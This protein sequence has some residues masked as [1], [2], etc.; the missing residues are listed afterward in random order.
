[1]DPRERGVSAARDAGPAARRSRRLSPPAAGEPSQ[2]LWP[3]QLSKKQLAVPRRNAGAGA[4]ASTSA[5][6][7]PPQ[8]QRRLAS[9][10]PALPAPAPAAKRSLSDDGPRGAGA[11]PDSASGSDSEH[12]GFIKVDR[13]KAPA[14]EPSL[15]AFK[16]TIPSSGTPA[17][18]AAAPARG[19]SLIPRART[20]LSK[21][22]ASLGSSLLRPPLGHGGGHPQCGRSPVPPA[23]ACA[24]SDAPPSIASPAAAAAASDSDDSSCSDDEISDVLDET[25]IQLIEAM[26]DTRIAGT[27]H[28]EPSKRPLASDAPAT[29]AASTMSLPRRP[30]RWMGLGDGAPAART[31]FAESLKERFSA[32]KTV[33]A[34]AG[35]QTPAQ[36]APG[37]PTR[38]KDADSDVSTAKEEP[39][40]GPAAT[41]VAAATTAA[42]PVEPEALASS[43]AAEDSQAASSG[44]PGPAPSTPAD[45]VEFVAPG[46]A[47]Q[48]ATSLL[49]RVLD[50][51]GP[52]IQQKMVEFL[53][54]DGVIA[55]LIGF[56]THCQGSIYS[57]GPSSPTASAAPPP[58]PPS[59][60]PDSGPSASPF[61]ETE[62]RR[63]HRARLMRQRCRSAGL[64]E[65]DLRRGFNAVNMLTSRDQH[66]RRVL[67]AKLSVIVPCLMAVFHEDSLGSFH[68]ACL[69]LEHCFTQSPLKTTRLLLYQQNPPSRWWSHSE[70]VARGHAPICDI[71][72]YLSEPCVQRLFLKAEFGV[73]TG[74]LMT[75]LN[76]SSNDAMVVPEELSRIG[77]GPVASA[78]GAAADDDGGASKAQSQQRSK[79]MQLVRNRFQQLNRGGFL[80]QAIEL[81]E[82]PDAYISENVAEFLAFMVSDCSTFYGFNILFKP[83]YDSELPVR[84][85]AQLILSS[86]SQRLT[87]QAVAATRL[88]HTLLTKTSCQ[89]GLRTREAQGIRDPELHP[90][91]S[92]VLVHVGH[93]ARTALES[94]LPGLF[95][96]ATGQQEAANLTSSHAAF[97]RRASAESLQL[98]EFDEADPEIDIDLTEADSSGAEGEAEDSS[99]EPAV[100]PLELGERCLPLPDEGLPGSGQSSGSDS[101]SDGDDGCKEADLRSSAAALLQST[102]PDSLGS[103][104]AS[105]S[106]SPSST[107]SAS[108]VAAAS[109]TPERPLDVSTG[110]RL[111]TEDLD[112]LVSLP[113]PDFSRLALLRI[114]IEVLR[115]CDDPDEVV[116]WIDLRVWR[117]LGTWFLNHPHNNMLHMSMYQL[118]SIITLEAVRLRKAR[119]ERPSFRATQRR[120]GPSK[121]PGPSSRGCL[122]KPRS[123]SVGASTRRS[124]ALAAETA[125][126]YL[127][128]DAQI[129]CE[130]EPRAQAAAKHRA[131]RRRAI[132]ERIRREEASSCDGVLTY[133]V[134][135]HRWIDKL[136]WRATSPNFDGARGYIAL[137][138][139]TLR[140]AIQAD[141]RR[142]APVAASGKAAASAAPAAV[143]GTSAAER[144][145]KSGRPA[146]APVSSSSSGGGGGDAD[147]EASDSEALLLDLAYHDP[148][149]R[150]R[151]GEYPLYR[152]QRW[153]ISML[154][155][156][157]FRAHLRPLRRQALLMA[158]RIVEFRLA[159][160]SHKLILAE[161]DGTG[162]RPVPFFSPQ[163]VRPPQKLENTEIKEKQ[164]QINVGLLLGRNRRAASPLLPASTARQ[165]GPSSAAAAA[166]AA[167]A[168]DAAGN[169]DGGAQPI[170]EVGINIDSLF[171]RML[172]F[173]EDLVS[174]P[175]AS[176][177][178]CGKEAAA[179]DDATDDDDDDERE[180][181]GR[182]GDGKARKAGA[183]GHSKAGSS[184]RKKPKAALGASVSELFEMAPETAADAA[185]AICSALA[186]E[187]AAGSRHASTPRARKK[188]TAAAGS[189]RRRRARLQ[190]RASNPSLTGVPASPAAPASSKPPLDAQHGD[191]AAAGLDSTMQSLDLNL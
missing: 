110:E 45:A 189:L 139:N 185:D 27:K 134:E 19:S 174:L 24:P 87:P 125:N 181:L 169:A 177:S 36:P 96:A 76:L 104:S 121:L 30:L 64:A 101:D 179:I 94:F 114:C 184:R 109:S 68:H 131:L 143:A 149:T 190:G 63:K 89:Y 4:G 112:L 73:W 171:A 140:L 162:Q 142:R 69:L 172:G 92:Q 132:A 146:A 67:E 111:D 186:S 17:P 168:S 159:D 7:A 62:R 176:H 61:Q 33:P 86:P 102:Y 188:P 80:A 153:E 141:R 60:R 150:E 167:A 122:R 22:T 93:A 1:M 58:P 11:D 50:I 66:A 44:L 97:N 124:T 15:A 41:G 29:S 37:P 42:A 99:P 163:R 191:S 39:A 59:L 79:A 78:L 117:A 51:D 71:L 144:P 88:L 18:T 118:M 65:A 107:L 145:A 151:L 20:T 127:S 32:P 166:A 120:Q 165:A 130:P 81:I 180:S 135:Q 13:W 182:D 47:K 138:L 34:A 21:A 16:P 105:S 35:R 12:D 70:S 133:L 74:R 2:L 40:K 77:L 170:D 31:G 43:S 187:G 98:P 8:A 152:L 85:L 156:P 178:G 91:G 52:V 100:P 49:R 14:A 154:Y 55:S 113:K 164:L 183:H 83:I 119:R 137:I 108:P 129:D 9:T 126:D 160:P 84:R 57:P 23:P 6:Q 75:S 155:S 46:V 72:P 28:K 26:E 175:P 10:P 173:T 95:A 157:A 48:T 115:E 82:D 103:G 136:I 147:D 106:L 56:I 116:G 5:A 158:R 53:L 54:I 123:S 128:A 25:E 3:G 161:S 38:A 90:R 148:A